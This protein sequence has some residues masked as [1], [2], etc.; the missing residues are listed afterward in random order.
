MS[1]AADVDAEGEMPGPGPWVPATAPVDV[2]IDELDLADQE[3]S[4][5]VAGLDEGQVA[6][7]STLEAVEPVL[8]ERA[9]M[10]VVDG[11]HRIAAAA[12]Q[13][14]ATV[15]ARFVEG[16]SDELYR[17]A[18]VLNA[19]HGVPMT[20][21]D[22]RAA[23]TSLLRRDPARSDRSIALDVGLAAATVAR[24][25]RSS[26]AQGEH[27]NVRRG[28]DGRW[29]AASVEAGK[30]H[31]RSLITEHPE[32][33]LR[34]VARLSGVSLG[35]AC[36][37]RAA[38]LRAE[39]QPGHCPAPPPRVSSGPRGTGRVDASTGSG[40]SSPAT[41]P[42]AGDPAAGPAG[43]S[44]GGS[45]GGP[46]GG[47]AGARRHAAHVGPDPEA[48]RL[49]ARLVRDPALCR[50]ERGREVLARLRGLVLQP[51]DGE[52][53]AHAVP[54]HQLL[55]TITILRASARSWIRLAN[56]LQE[57]SELPFQGQAPGRAEGD[58]QP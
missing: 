39:P 40:P 27:L 16:S 18:V 12:R 22:R 11:R 28:R 50:T 13:G 46:A 56:T 54:P 25:R 8:V 48:M 14:R 42:P 51:E 2:R 31:A 58:Q 24:L 15:A 45:T 44:T 38:V 3:F 6:H 49:L 21:P 37:V 52:R 36:K 47:P 19:S 23:A 1:A 9:T 20:L 43:G 33:T 10:R 35:T 41:S 55:E 4:V 7:L 17:L 34:E 57:R 29:R 26:T 53:F 30:A 5:R 32:L